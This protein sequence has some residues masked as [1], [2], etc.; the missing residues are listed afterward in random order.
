MNKFIGIGRLTKDIELRYTSSNIAVATFT[1]AINQEYLSKDGNR[2]VDFIN[3][4]TY[5]IQAEN[6]AKYC[7]KGSQVAIEGR[8]QTRNY[9]DKD[10]KKV[11]IT[12]IKVNSV[13][14]IQS[15]EKKENTPKEEN[16][17]T[18]EEV[19]ESKSD[20]FAE[21]GSEV[22]FTDDDLPF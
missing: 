16:K 3:C 9:D 7:S 22:Q 13:E 12:E 19:E 21:F 8:I 20:P 4:V 14:F 11:Y 6:I 17:I 10:G 5:K 2:G 18:P 1:I 15:I